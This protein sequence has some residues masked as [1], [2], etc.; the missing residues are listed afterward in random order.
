ML[1][2]T[3]RVALRAIALE[4]GG[5]SETVTVQAEAVKVQT[6]SGERSA[7][8]T[9]S[10]IDDIALKGRDFTGMLKTAAG[11]HR[12]VQPR[13][14]GL[15][16]HGRHVDQ[17]PDVVQLLLRRRHQQGHRL[18]QRQLRRAGA[19]LDRR[20]QVQTS[21]FQAEYGRSSGRDDHRR[22]QQRHEG[23]PRQRG[24]LQARRERSTR[25][26]VG[27]PASVRRG[28]RPRSAQAAATRFDN[29]AWTL[30]GPVLIPGTDFNK[31]RE[32]AVLLLLAGHPAA[33]RSRRRCS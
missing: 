1:G 21:N 3:E 31:D 12:H 11:R 32:Q 33:Q 2:A 15:G 22:H 19:R 27:P 14:A 7:T 29:T 25:N 10:K 4:V 17:R 8:I 13:S 28:R 26:D 24:V 23:F 30:G 9:A 5:L 20:S 16:Q 18:E 6:T